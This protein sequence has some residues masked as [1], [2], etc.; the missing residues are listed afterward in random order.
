MHADALEVAAAGTE[1]VLDPL[2]GALAV[3]GLDLDH[4]AL[5][6][7]A[8]DRGVGALQRVVGERG[9]NSTWNRPVAFM[10]GD[11]TGARGPIT[12]SCV[13]ASHRPPNARRAS[14]RR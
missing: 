13:A 6:L 3:G 4:D 8:D 5:A 2:H 11:P 10:A 12:S 14:Y 1:R 7:A 9:P